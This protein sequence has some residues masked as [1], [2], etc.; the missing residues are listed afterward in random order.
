MRV[1]TK[2]S[3]ADAALPAAFGLLGERVEAP[4][5]VLGQQRGL[6][7]AQRRERLQRPGDGG[8]LHHAAVVAAVQLGQHR[9]HQ[10]RLLDGGAQIA[11]RPLLA[12]AEPQHG[13]VEARSR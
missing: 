4:R 3:V 13:A 7:V 10:T 5:D 6:L 1:K 11:P 8:L 12:R 2:P 9:P